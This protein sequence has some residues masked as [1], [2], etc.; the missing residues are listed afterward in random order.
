MRDRRRGDIVV[1]SGVDQS[2]Y[3][4]IELYPP[5]ISASPHVACPGISS[6]RDK[7]D[8]NPSMAKVSKTRAEEANSISEM[9]W[10]EIQAHSLRFSPLSKND[11]TRSRAKTTVLARHKLMHIDSSSGCLSIIFLTFSGCLDNKKL[12]K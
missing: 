5:C 4:S 7:N 12:L 10:K 3:Y 2:L 8:R 9:G 1:S 6:N 11:T